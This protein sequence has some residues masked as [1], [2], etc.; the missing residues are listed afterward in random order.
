MTLIEP[1]N[2]AQVAGT[3]AR[4]IEELAS[5]MFKVVHATQIDGTT[6]SHRI[7]LLTTQASKHAMI[8][9][10]GV[11][12][13]ENNLLF[14]PEMAVAGL[15]GGLKEKSDRI[16]N[17]I[18]TFR[19]Q[20]KNFRVRVIESKTV[21]A[22]PKIKITGKTYNSEDDLAMAGMLA[23]YWADVIT[24]GQDPSIR[25]MRHADLKRVEGF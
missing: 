1:N 23:A 15:R 21:L 10:F 18:Y 5:P 20:L 22:E 3:I 19:E 11:L 25:F 13:E 24:C 9:T 16:N 7:G 12:L 2:A 14:H 6:K 17:A 4:S 8:Q